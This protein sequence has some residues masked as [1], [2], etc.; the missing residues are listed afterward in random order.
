MLLQ[1]EKYYLRTLGDDPRKVSCLEHSDSSCIVPRLQ[2][3]HP[4]THTP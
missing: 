4:D 1:E 3:T 2:Y